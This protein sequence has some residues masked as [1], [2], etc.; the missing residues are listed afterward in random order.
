MRQTFHIYQQMRKKIP[1]LLIPMSSWGAVGEIWFLMKNR[2]KIKITG[3]E[4][5]WVKAKS[6]K[7]PLSYM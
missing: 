2:P 1:H 7:Y 5:A 3:V 4:I 6:N